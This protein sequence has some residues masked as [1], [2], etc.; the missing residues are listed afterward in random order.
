MAGPLAKWA[1]DLTLQMKT[2]TNQV[3]KSSDAEIAASNPDS[4]PSAGTTRKDRSAANPGKGKG[5]GKRAP[6]VSPTSPGL[7]SAGQLAQI[8]QLIAAAVGREDQGKKCKR[9]KGSRYSSVVM[10]VDI[11]GSEVEVITDLVLTG[12]LNF[13]DYITV[14]WHEWSSAKRKELMG[15]VRNFKLT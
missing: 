6:P 4:I 1:K 10:K 14:E 8:S 3:N 5:C 12:A 2:L 7:F 11:E 15:L 9:G 13:V